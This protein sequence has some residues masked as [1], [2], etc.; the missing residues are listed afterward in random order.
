MILYLVKLSFLNGSVIKTFPDKQKVKES[1]AS[2][3]SLQEKLKEI[4]LAERM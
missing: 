2:R 1:F 4:L 3:H